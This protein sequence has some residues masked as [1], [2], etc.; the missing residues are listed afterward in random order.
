MAETPTNFED[1]LASLKQSFV[2]G[3]PGRIEGIDRLAGAIG[4][5]LASNDSRKDIAALRALVH[6]L[7]GAGG[8]FGHLAVGD[9]AAW[10]ERACDDI[11]GGD[12]APTADQWRQV[13][14]RLQKLRHAAADA[15]T[16]A[17]RKIA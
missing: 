14:A 16:A 4:E 1:L 9:A 11:L 15:M 3:L 5:N 13:E 8:T 7:A 12:G 6:K 10:V 17:G 2:Q